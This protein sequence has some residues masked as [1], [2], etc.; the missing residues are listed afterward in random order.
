MQKELVKLECLKLAHRADRRAEEVVAM[1]KIY[2]QYILEE[3]PS[4]VLV[5]EPEEVKKKPGRPPKKLLDGN[6]SN[7]AI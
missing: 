6:S 2:E 7:G 5:E 3:P 4:K 1:A